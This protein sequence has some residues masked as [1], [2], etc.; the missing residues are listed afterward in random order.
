MTTTARPASAPSAVAFASSAPAPVP[1]ASAAPSVASIRLRRA[2]RALAWLASVSALAA[3]L[4]CITD[5]SRAGDATLVVQTWR[6]YG[7]F[8][9]AGLFAIL[10]RR[11][12]RNG[13]LWA[14]A[15]ANKAALTITAIQYLHLGG[16]AEAS[17]TLGWDGALTVT[18]VTAYVLIRSAAGARPP[19]SPASGHSD[20]PPP[21]RR[22]SAR[23]WVP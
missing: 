22:R 10:A 11:P 13:A 5:V 20:T 23:P 4:S 3:A 12:E 19:P 17:K 14:L 9:C 15:I 16:V 8:L 6:M 21:D 7:L 18:L 2:G 1:S